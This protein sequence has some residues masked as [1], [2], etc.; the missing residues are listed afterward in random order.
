M[1]AEHFKQVISI[2]DS[3]EYMKRL[4]K[5]IPWGKIKWGR[6]YLPRLVYRV[7]GDEPAPIKKLITHTEDF[8]KCSVSGVWCNYYRSGNDYTPPHQDNY[9]SHVITYSFGGTR[10]FVC[11]NLY[12]KQKKN[13]ILNSGDV[14]VFSPEFDNLHNHSIPKTK[15]LVDPRISIVLFTTTPYSHNNLTIEK[16]IGNINDIINMFKD[17]EILIGENVLYVENGKNILEIQCDKNVIFSIIN[18]LYPH[19]NV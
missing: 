13:Y 17:G 19:L 12:T 10:R 5:D 14:F 8:F 11:Q 1:E 2:E 9:K 16:P 4:S 6:G 18:T 15:K 7:E 3:N